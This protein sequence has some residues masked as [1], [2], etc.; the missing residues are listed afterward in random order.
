MITVIKTVEE[1]KETVRKWKAQG[2]TVGLVPTM[3]FLHEGHLS[4]IKEAAAENDRVVVSVFVNPK[5]FAQSEDLESYPRDIER[6][7]MLSEGA[8]A[9]VV[10][11]PSV[12]EMYPDDFCSSVSMTGLQGQLCGKTRPGH[13]AGVC[14]VVNKLFNIVMPDRA[15]FGE[16]DAQQ[17]AI[18]RHMVKD[19]NMNLEVVGCPTVREA[20]GLAKSSRN[21]YLSE[22]ERKAAAVL[23]R[24]LT[25]A[26]DMIDA[27]ER[28][29]T[30][31]VEKMRGIIETEPLADVEY[32]DIVDGDTIEKIDS[33]GGNVL[34]ALAVFIGRTRLIDNISMRV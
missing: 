2:L 6:D 34:I 5:Q 27:G 32:I 16:K 15:Y 12:D 21:S 11:N 14:T 30:S 10:F 20:D 9:D 23:Y 8:G 28:D 33:I 19:L 17:L 3:G 26:R 13:F 25:A 29:V 18:I 4:L 22:D 1:T 7:I 24:A 31:V